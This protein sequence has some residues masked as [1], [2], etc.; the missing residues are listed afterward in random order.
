MRRIGRVTAG[1]ALVHALVVASCAG[2]SD[3]SGEVVVFA[4]A[5]LT[6]AFRAIEA[7]YEATHAAVDVQ[8]NLAGS[9]LLRE[10]IL[11]G[12]PADVF[13]SAS[14]AILDEVVAAGAA[15]GPVE[16]FARNRLQIAV[17]RGNPAGVVGL[18]DLA[19]ESLIIGLCAEGVPCGDLARAALAAAGVTPSIDTNEP[20]V[21]AL[22]TK[23]EVGELDAAIVYATDVIAAGDLV[24]GIPVPAVADIRAAYPITLLDDAPHPQEAAGF[25]AFVRSPQGRGILADLG[26]AVP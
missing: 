2:G 21:R 10:Q 15:S 6:D 8:L 4:A 16:V 18:A 26:F 11:E 23:V 12:A 14:V 9:A 19:R 5:S 3:D 1:V 20:D 7:A 13:A 25:V 24:E 17:P 22:L